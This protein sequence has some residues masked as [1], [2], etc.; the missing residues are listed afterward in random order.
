MTPRKIVIR[1]PNWVGD[2]VL[3]VP[4]IKAVRRQFPDARITLMVRPWVAGLFR[5]PT[6]VDEV[7][8]HPRPGR[9]AWIPTAL[10]TRRRDFDLALLLP[11]S[12]ESAW[13]AFAGRVPVR[14]GYATDSR[15]WLLTH[16]VR[17]RREKV[18]QVDYYMA[19]VRESF[20]I[21]ELRPDIGLVATPE[22]RDRARRL[23]ADNG[24]DPTAGILVVNPGA[25]F[26]SAKRWFEDRFADVADRLWERRHLTTVM[27]G[28]AT[29]RGIA[30]RI[31]DA[32]S[33]PAA[34]L[35]GDTD[36]ET[37][38][39]VLSL[40]SMVITNDSG[41]MHLAAALGVPTLAVF[42]STDA[43][44]TGPV[45]P[46]ARLVRHEVSCSPCLLRECPIDHRCM[47]GVTVDQVSD[48]AL[49]ML[50]A[51]TAPA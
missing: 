12:F 50:A 42:G 25:A 2:A 41:P 11:N 26:G 40:A 20:G 5:P 21:R 38:R 29:E 34:I 14:I 33:T 48:A 9:T 17:R 39:G 13:T 27:V 35:S 15:R 44:V 31:R 6:F 1:G 23:L 19:L 43:E 37:L 3:A 24:I 4:A 10:E 36:L 8:T 7:W 22:D 47:K 28:S 51:G 32:M 45:G 18:H 46:R 16:P 49:E 30:A